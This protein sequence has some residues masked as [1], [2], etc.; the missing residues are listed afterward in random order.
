MAA[1]K[2]KKEVHVYV[3]DEEHWLSFIN[4]NNTKLTGNLPSFRRFI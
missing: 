4:E 2:G 1:A 3:K